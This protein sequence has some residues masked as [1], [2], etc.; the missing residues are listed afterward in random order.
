MLFHS[1]RFV[2]SHVFPYNTCRLREELCYPISEQSDPT[3]GSNPDHSIKSPVHLVIEIL[4]NYLLC[5]NFLWRGTL[6]NNIRIM[7]TVGSVGRRSTN[8]STNTRSICRSSIGWH[9]ADTRPIYRPTVG[10]YVGQ[11][12]AEYLLTLGWYMAD[13]SADSRPSVGWVSVE[14]RSSVGWYVGHYSANT[15]LLIGRY[16]TFEHWCIGW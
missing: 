3:Q 16:L 2:S 4:L 8:I 5:V 15:R 9:L 7:F 11:V 14:Y 12:S 10:R 6:W 1:N 13:I